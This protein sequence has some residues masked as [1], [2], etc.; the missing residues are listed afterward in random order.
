MMVVGE[1][2]EGKHDVVVTIIRQVGVR[3]ELV[4]IISILWGWA[5]VGFCMP[6]SNSALNLSLGDLQTLARWFSIM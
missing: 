2:R 1:H 4:D 6:F 5:P 3:C